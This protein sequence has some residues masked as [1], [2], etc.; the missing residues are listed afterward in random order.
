MIISNTPFTSQMLGGNFAEGFTRTHYFDQPFIASQ[1]LVHVNNFHNG[2]SMTI[3]MHGCE[4]SINPG[5][6]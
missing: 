3:L 1:V 4:Q 5:N 6:V 2:I